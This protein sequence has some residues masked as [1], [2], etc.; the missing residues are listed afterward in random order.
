MQQ[1]CNTLVVHLRL[2]R[3][4]KPNIVLFVPVLN[5]LADVYC[6]LILRAGTIRHPYLAYN[7]QQ[8]FQTSLYIK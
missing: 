8:V 5:D 3:L 4:R 7:K 6:P 1:S 2:N